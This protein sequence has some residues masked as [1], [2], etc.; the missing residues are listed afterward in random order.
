MEIKEEVKGVKNM[1]LKI[2]FISLYDYETY[3]GFEYVPYTVKGYTE[4]YSNARKC[5][6]LVHRQELDNRPIYSG[7][8]GPMFNG[9]TTENGEKILN[10]RY[11]TQ[12][13]YNELC[14]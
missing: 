2:D 3:P 7:Y 8:L 11:E 12:Q 14:K 9:Y 4:D 6:A 1:K 13:A 10:L 5:G